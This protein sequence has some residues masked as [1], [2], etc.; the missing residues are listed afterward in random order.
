[1]TSASAQSTALAHTMAEAGLASAR[2]NLVWDDTSSERPLT[3]V[4]LG[5][6]HEWMPETAVVTGSA[7][8]ITELRVPYRG[9]ELR[10][11]ELLDQLDS[12]VSEGLAEPSFRDAIAQVVA[13]SQWL[14]A[15]GQR[16]ALIGAGAELSPLAPL[17][18]WGADV[19]AIEIAIPAVWERIAEIARDSAGTVRWSLRPDGEPGMD[20]TAD[21]H[22]VAAWLRANGDIPLVLGMYAYADR[23]AH[24]RVTMAIDLLAEYLCQQDPRTA[25]AYLA[26]PTDAFVVP[27]EVVDAGK[28][29]WRDR[30]PRQFLD[31]PA[32]MLSGGRLFKPSYAT[33]HEDGSGVADILVPAQGP[34]YALAKRLQ[35]WRG[36]CAGAAGHR[37]SFNVAPASWTRSVTRNRALA[38]AYGG[39]HHFDVEVFEPD[40]CRAL[41]AALLVHDLHQPA[42]TRRHP[43]ELFSDQALHGGLWRAAYEPKSALGFAAVLGARHGRVAN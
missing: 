42:P 28:A 41:M 9:R 37:V 4:E 39:A 27:P 20:V 16:I 36:V 14:R 10:G 21:L 18:S 12:W 6:D 19:A 1:M 11:H 26:T 33:V 23:G 34:N 43:E 7:T 32:R 8:A 30:G 35:R 24:V 25:L 15:P 17:L 22:E 5:A 40:T 38:A 3:E 13:N 31:T 29:A 2:R